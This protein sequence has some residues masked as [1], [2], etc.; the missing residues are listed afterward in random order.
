M[1]KFALKNG[2]FS[3]DYEGDESFLK[4][5][6]AKILEALNHLQLASPP[7]IGHEGDASGSRGAA[8]N[9]SAPQLP[10][11]STNTI[12]KLMN[13]T[14]GPDLILAAVA[15]V[16]LVDGNDVASRREITA[17]MKAASSYYKKTYLNN[18]SAYLDTLTKAD[19]VRLVSQDTYG[20]PAKERERIE[21][22]ICEQ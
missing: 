2:P 5:D 19:R 16:I 21:Q 14:T 6:L 15:K 1:I 17:E 7:L 8:E 18:L 20:L 9:G 4:N 22:I 3:L 13:V 11:H 10:K 12:A